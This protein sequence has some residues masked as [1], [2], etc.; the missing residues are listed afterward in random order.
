MGKEVFILTHGI[1]LTGSIGVGK[2]TVAESLRGRG[3]TVLESD[4]LARQMVR[5]GEP[6]HRE[7]R[8][9][10]GESVMG[11]GG[12]LDRSKLAQIV[13]QDE[14][15]RRRLEGILHPKI[16]ALWLT[17]A[18]RAEGAGHWVAVDVPLLYETQADRHFQN[19]VTVACS[20][21]TQAARLAQRGWTC[22]QTESRLR[23]QLSQQEKMDR[24]DHVIWNEFS[25]SNME[26]QLQR[27]VKALQEEPTYASQKE[28]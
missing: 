14:R 2:T 27:V 18:E 11:P 21:P 13:F 5:P 20:D 15:Q 12:E 10:F 3:W 23:A 19:V 25:K 17:E 7:I 28:K 1:A 9:A 8:E 16:R 22:E 26:E 24:A 6:A 4:V